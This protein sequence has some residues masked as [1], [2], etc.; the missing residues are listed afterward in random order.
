MELPPV[1][2]EAPYQHRRG[3]PTWSAWK[4]LLKPEGGADTIVEGEHGHQVASD[5][6]PVGLRPGDNVGRVGERAG[7]RL[8]MTV[9]YGMY[10]HPTTA[11]M[12]SPTKR[13]AWLRRCP[14][15]ICSHYHRLVYATQEWQHWVGQALLFWFMVSLGYMIH[16]G[17]SSFK[18]L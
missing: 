17:R 5:G 1:V 16:L 14:G 4:R 9:L 18:K 12:S 11:N 13:A 10:R 6:N 3:A 8:N 15:H 2:P 7:G